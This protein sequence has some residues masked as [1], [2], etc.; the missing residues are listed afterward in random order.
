MTQYAQINMVKQQ[1]RTMGVVDENLIKLFTTIPRNVFVPS[2]YADFA[3]SD[4]Q[5]PL[6]HGQTM[7]T[8]AEEGQILQA[9]QL[10][11]SEVVLEVGT[12]SGYFTALLSKLC[13]KVITVDVFEEFTLKAQEKLAEFHCRNVSFFTANAYAGFPE[14][15]PYDC[16]IISGALP[17]I[18]NDFF[19]QLSTGGHLISIIGQNSVQQV[20][21]H[22]LTPHQLK[23]GRFLFNT[24]IPNL[25]PIHQEKRFIF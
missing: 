13:K 5:I 16:I 6:S 20:Q 7:L 25:I 17:S 18:P 21:I 12:G 15:S 14:S 24:Y 22:T 19:L 11:G 2:Q 3:Y 8:P 23:T 4:M 1:L 10:T 9:L